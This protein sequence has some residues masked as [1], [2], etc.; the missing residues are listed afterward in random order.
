MPK[1]GLRLHV[2][3]RSKIQQSLMNLMKLNGGGGLGL[4]KNTL[5][6]QVEFLRG[7]GDKTRL[8]IVKALMGR[9]K[10]VTQLVKEL[11]SSQANIS[12]HLKTL[13]NSGILKSRQEGK[14]V[15]YSLGDE[16]IQ[17]F[18]VYMEDMLI[19]LNQKAQESI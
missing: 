3:R 18:V 2:M 5:E 19:S 12:G 4:F 8:K 10:T 17:E 13:K 7:L 16:M 11:G 1:S 15:F 9:E 6:L 14:Y